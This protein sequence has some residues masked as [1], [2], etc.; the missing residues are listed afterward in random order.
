MQDCKRAQVTVD[1][2]KGRGK[3]RKLLHGVNYMPNISWQSIFDF[4][5]D[6]AKM[7]F[8]VA[9]THDQ[10]LN[11]A[12]QRIVDTHLI[13]SRFDADAEDEK[14]YF[15]DATDH[16]LQTTLKCGT[17]IYYRLGTSIEHT[18]DDHHFNTRVPAD[19]QQYAKI[20]SGII[21]HYNYGW[22]NGFHMNIPIWEIWNE[23]DL[24]GKCWMGTREEFVDFFCTVLK[25]LKTEFP[26]ETIGGPA[27]CGFHEDW[28][29]PI[30]E[31]C[32][33]ENIPL[34]FISWHAY[35]FEPAALINESFRMRELLDRYGFTETG[36]HLN[37]WHYLETWDGLSRNVNP[38]TFHEIMFGEK[39]MH[40]CDSACYNAAMF[41]GW[42]DSPMDCSCYYGAGFPSKFSAW[43]FHDQ[44]FGLTANYYSMKMIGEIV[45]EYEDRFE[46]QGGNAN[47]WLLPVCDAEKKKGAVLLADYRGRYDAVEL[48][49]EGVSAAKNFKC[50][51]LDQ[52][53]METEIPIEF[54]AG[55]LTLIK[56]M[57]VSTMFLVTFDL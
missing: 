5:E 37:E 36:I 35:W 47:L 34:D 16:L 55:K 44:T 27:L 20:L 3:L 4:S 24:G 8:T 32:K 49:I 17:Q 21:R 15:F 1:F 26:N 51:I 28:L 6:Y 12:G 41:I 22:A 52:E 11:N 7:H 40:G 50:R 39:G 10:A 53:N 9:R 2:S 54:V 56:K 43:G 42:H 38:E 31:R 23:A 19:F 48:K 18:L 46:A 29:V 30:L 45:H 25:Y 13:F 57:P 33:A 14:N